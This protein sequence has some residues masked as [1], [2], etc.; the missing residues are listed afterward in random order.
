MKAYTYIND[1][2]VL[3][4][5]GSL[6]PYVVYSYCND[7]FFTIFLGYQFLLLVC[8]FIHYKNTYD[9]DTCNESI[10]NVL[11]ELKN[12]QETNSESTDKD[13]I[14]VQDNSVSIDHF[15]H[16]VMET[17]LN[18]SEENKTQTIECITFKY[19]HSSNTYDPNESIENK[20]QLVSALHIYENNTSPRMILCITDKKQPALYIVTQR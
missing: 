4:S 19:V 12:L 1:L 14:D 17:Y 20:P 10:N 13:D 5:I 2:L 16:Y 18:S 15:Q 7:Y 6:L 9:Y 11:I 8:C 3:L